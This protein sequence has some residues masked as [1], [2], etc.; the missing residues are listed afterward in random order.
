MRKKV[1]LGEDLTGN[2]SWMV[3]RCAVDPSW[4]QP[5]TGRAVDPRGFD[6]DC[7]MGTGAEAVSRI[8]GLERDGFRIKHGRVTLYVVTQT[9]VLGYPVKMTA[10]GTLTESELA[11]TEDSNAIIFC[12]WQPGSDFIYVGGFVFRKRFVEESKFIEEGGKLQCTAA[13]NDGYRYPYV[14]LEPLSELPT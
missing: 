11:D 12:R 14:R 13:P 9:F 5:A 1:M 4:V 10:M 6:I 8:L 3:R 7:I 2:K